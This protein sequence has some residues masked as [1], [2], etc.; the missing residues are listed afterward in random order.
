M[1]RNQSSF[2]WP[3]RSLS[4]FLEK[5]ES[6]VKKKESNLKQM[7]E[8]DAQEE[9]N[10]LI[11]ISEE[12]TQEIKS[13]ETY[14]FD[15]LE[16][17]LNLMMNEEETDFHGN[18]I[19]KELFKTDLSLL[20]NHEH[21]ATFFRDTYPPSEFIPIPNISLSR[22]DSN[23]SFTD[24]SEILKSIKSIDSFNSIESMNSF[25]NKQNSISNILRKRLQVLQNDHNLDSDDESV[26]TL[27]TIST[28][29]LELPH[30]NQNQNQNQFK[31]RRSKLILQ[32]LLL[33]DD[34]QQESLFLQNSWDS[35]DQF[36]LINDILSI[37]NDP[38][39]SKS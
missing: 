36:Q 39:H 25:Q 1:V 37:L 13:E 31:Q 9:F 38:N 19:Q 23:D 14:L 34:D 24:Q 15:Q 2:N 35:S 26:D 33:L 7:I 21:L 28:T 32:D 29:E 18:L 16:G 4:T 12:L 22:S 11:E 6:F 5:Y 10:E 17:K 3:N 27:E 30:Q 20:E 8:I